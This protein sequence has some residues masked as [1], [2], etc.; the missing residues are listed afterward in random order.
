MKTVHSVLR[1]KHRRQLLKTESLP[2]SQQYVPFGGKRLCALKGARPVI[3]R[4]ASAPSRTLGRRKLVR[5]RF[6]IDTDVVFDSDPD[7]SS[8]PATAASAAAVASPPDTDRWVEEQ[9]DL[10][11]YE[12][13]EDE[14]E[15]KETDI[16]SDG[17]EELCRRLARSAAV[18][19]RH[20]SLAASL[21]SEESEE[22][23]S[24][25]EETQRAGEV[26]VRRES[27]CEE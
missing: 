6:T 11:E 16:L 12:D 9:F 8:P 15:V 20:A 4:A 21:D 14:A 13:R 18:D 22:P 25:A 10:D 7:L 2:L 19:G 3:N 5:N 27:D 24:P 23:A 26:W 1:E 17:E